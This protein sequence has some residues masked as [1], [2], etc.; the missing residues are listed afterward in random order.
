MNCSSHREGIAMPRLEIGIEAGNTMEPRAI[1][2]GWDPHVGKREDK[3]PQKRPWRT[4]NGKK[5]ERR[6][7]TGESN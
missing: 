4:N 3:G 5:A 6:R 1:P 7:M 2:L